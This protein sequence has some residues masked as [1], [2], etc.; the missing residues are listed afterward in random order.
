MII[1]VIRKIIDSE[2][3]PVSKTEKHVSNARSKELVYE[4]LGSTKTPVF[5]CAKGQFVMADDFDAIVG[6]HTVLWFLNGDSQLSEPAKQA[7][8]CSEN[9]K[10]LQ[11]IN[12]RFCLKIN[13]FI[14]A[15]HRP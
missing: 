13:I 3:L 5:G 6:Y 10:L 7:I 8:L 4:M 11:I 9:R 15:G 14:T 2:L 12:C 1:D